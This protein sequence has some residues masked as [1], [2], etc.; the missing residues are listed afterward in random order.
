MMPN[1]I[2]LLFKE[3]RDVFLP[4]DGKPMDDDLLSIQRQQCDRARVAAAAAWLRRRRRQLS[5]GAAAVA[6]A[7]PASAISCRQGEFNNQQGRE[8]ATEGS[9][10][11]TDGRTMMVIWNGR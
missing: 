3:A 9:G 2:I 1:A 10:V 4:L 8:A 6:A 7:A 5:S 11:G